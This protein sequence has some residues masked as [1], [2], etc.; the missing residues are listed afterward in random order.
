MRRSIAEPLALLD[1]L[2]PWAVAVN[3]VPVSVQDDAALAPLFSMVP[4]LAGSP[5]VSARLSRGSTSWLATATIYRLAHW[6]AG[7]AEGIREAR[8]ALRR[9]ARPAAPERQRR[10]RDVGAHRLLD[11]LRLAPPA[12]LDRLQP[13]RGPTRPELLRPA[14][15]RMPPGELPVDR[16]GRRPAGALVP[17]R[18]RADQDQRGPRTGELERV[19]V[20]VH[21]AAAGD[22]RLAQHASGRDVRDRRAPPRSTTARRAASRGA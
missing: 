11:P 2:A 17:A 5:K 3:E 8:P 19:D 1:S 4:S 7:I 6:A 20:R 16:E 18:S 10:P 22:A 9:A 14:R 13:E 12:L 21:D 15:E